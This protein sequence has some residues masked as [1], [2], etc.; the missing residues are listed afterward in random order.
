MRNIELKESDKDKMR[1]LNAKNGWGIDYDDIMKLVK[2][3]EKLRESNPYKCA[4]IEYRLTDIN[5][6]TE[7]SLISVGKYEEA[8]ESIEKCFS[9]L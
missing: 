6:H 3:H 1:A 5:C 2:Q 4:L 9:D 7:V 8:R